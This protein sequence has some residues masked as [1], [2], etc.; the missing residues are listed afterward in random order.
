MERDGSVERVALGGTFD[1]LHDG[2]RALF[3]RA[4]MLGDVTVGLTTDAFAARI[5]PDQ[6]ADVDPYG[7][8]L[9]TLDREL[10][11]WAD[12]RARCYEIRPLRVPTGIAHEPQF[13][14]LVVSPETEPGGERI[15]DLRRDRGI[16]PLRIEVVEHVRAADGDIISS[17][18]IRAGEIDEHGNL[19]PTA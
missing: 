10:R 15:N 5:R 17:T 6:E 9:A 18:R 11:A 7:T 16:E 12:R 2:H 1:P 4:F 8:R 14:S 13:D 19:L 3:F